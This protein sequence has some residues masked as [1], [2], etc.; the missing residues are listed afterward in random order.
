MHNAHRG[1]ICICCP[2]RHWINKPGISF[3]S[4]FHITPLLLLCGYKC[5]ASA[6]IKSCSAFMLCPAAANDGVLKPTLLSISP[7]LLCCCRLERAT[8]AWTISHMNTMVPPPMNNRPQITR[9]SSARTSRIFVVHP[10]F[11][12]ILYHSSSC[13]IYL[14]LTLFYQN[15]NVSLCP[16]CCCCC[17]HHVVSSSV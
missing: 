6:M 11:R 3:I 15:K 16:C 12:T 8:P 2:F 13:T 17:Y 1:Y 5:T 7:T 14:V 10:Y 4:S 9:T